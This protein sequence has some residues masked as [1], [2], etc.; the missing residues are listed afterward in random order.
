MKKTVF[1]GFVFSVLISICFA[2]G[3]NLDSNNSQQSKEKQRFLLMGGLDDPLLESF[4]DNYRNINTYQAVWSTEVNFED[5]KYKEVERIQIL[6]E[7]GIKKTR[8]FIEVA[9]DRK[10]N[11]LFYSAKSQNFLNNQW[12]EM[13]MPGGSKML[14]VYNDGNLS[15]QTDM[16]TEVQAAEKHY[17]DP[18][19]FTYRDFRRAVWVFP[20]PF[21]LPL[22]ASPVPIMEMLQGQ[23]EKLETIKLPAN[24]ASTPHISEKQK[25]SRENREL[26]TDSDLKIN[27]FP[28]YGET[29]VRLIIDGKDGFLNEWSYF[30]SGIEK[31]ANSTTLK[32]QNVKVN[33]PLDRSVFD[34]DMQKQKMFGPATESSKK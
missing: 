1:A 32:L 14:A 11:S 28:K 30:R 10:T 5:S 23:P 19:E 17:D 25:A 24:T 7:K 6:I 4:I 13:K 3:D 18:N 29:A 22:L 34:F 2:T 27:I 9:F 33:M 26:V 12:V 8:S 31:D 21:D 20:I 16:L 15:V